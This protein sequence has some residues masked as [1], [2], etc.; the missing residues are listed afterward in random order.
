M[1][2]FAYVSVVLLSVILFWAVY[3][4]CIIFAGIR[5][6]RKF[7]SAVGVLPKFSL[8]VPAKNEAVVVGRCLKALLDVDYPKDKLEV[9]VVD[10]G[11]SDGTDEICRG[12]AEAH[13]GIFRVIREDASRGK[14]AALNLALPF[15]SGEVVGVFDADS[16]P[17]KNVLRKVAS[18]FAD[19]S[20]SAVQGSTTS[21]NE[22]Q[23][24][25]TKVA[26]MEDKAWFQGLL[27]GREKLHLFVAF[28]GSCQFVRS[29]I[30]KSL[31]GW[32]ESSLVEDV[33]LSL[34]LVKV[35]YHVKF[36]ADVSSGRRLLLVCG[37]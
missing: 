7:S 26:A 3:H 31:G 36:A 8:I 23:N 28:T 12:F 16:V 11:S 25:L 4:A 27:A 13:P 22:G 24:M 10:G 29:S 19:V 34:R 37:G 18:Y 17:E 2:V 1:N 20:V 6:K 35:G 21:V 32:D 30:L 14:P 5:G 15:V 9:I 33:E